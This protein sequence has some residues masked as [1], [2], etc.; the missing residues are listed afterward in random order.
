LLDNIKTKTKLV[1]S[2]DRF[3]DGSCNHYRR[4]VENGDKLSIT[5]NKHTSTLY[6]TTQTQDSLTLTNTDRMPELICSFFQQFEMKCTAY[7]KRK[8]DQT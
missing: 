1:L 4:P 8:K 5:I 7:E 2:V 6:V 3:T